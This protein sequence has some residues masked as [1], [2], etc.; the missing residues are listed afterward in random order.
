[1]VLNSLMNKK[2][3]NLLPTHSST[4]DLAD[5]FRQYFID[6]IAIICESFK[7][8]GDAFEYELFHETSCSFTN[9]QKLGVDMKLW[10]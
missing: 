4:V 10:F 5:T 1:M 3:D 6:K 2:K 7:V 9:F 8:K